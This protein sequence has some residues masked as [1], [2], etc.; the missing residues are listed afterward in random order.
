[1]LWNLIFSGLL[2]RGLLLLISRLINKTGQRQLQKFGICLRRFL[3]FSGVAFIKLGQFL[4]TRHDLVGETIA[5]ELRVLQNK[6]KPSS[7]RL[8]AKKLLTLRNSITIDEQP[9]ASGSISHVYKGYIEDN[10]KSAVAIKVLRP[11]IR[12][13]FLKNLQLLRKFVR[14]LAI[15]K[16]L[17][18]LRLEEA[19]DIIAEAAEVELNMHLEGAACDKLRQN[20]EQSNSK[21]RFP[22]VFWQFSSKNILVMEWIDGVP[23]FDKEGIE[24]LKINVPLLCYNIATSFFQQAHNDGFFHADIHGGN[25]LVS[26]TGIYMID[27]G[28]VSHLSESDKIAI[29]RIMHA[30]IHGD[31]DRVAEIHFA[32]GYIDKSKSKANFA[33][34]CRAIALPINNLAAN[35]ISMANMLIGI[36]E[37][38]RT[39]EMEGQP[40]LVLLQKTMI[41]LE[42]SLRH[43]NQSLNM[44]QIAKPWFSVWQ[45]E[46][47]GYKFALKQLL[48]STKKRIE[49][50][51]HDGNSHFIVTKNDTKTADSVPKTA[52]FAPKNSGTPLINLYRATLLGLALLL[53]LWQ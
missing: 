22:K 43:L 51:Y 32:A 19:I 10:A 14:L 21:L 18:R 12:Y 28:I 24:R 40:Q 29:A 38:M 30:F 20:A 8:M 34:A 7:A 13:R 52:D 35:K 49:S 41:S 5:A 2:Y 39:F 48:K 23:L 33:L 42:G 11:L 47:M 25:I 26:K 36:L 53:Y 3:L 6:V 46:N 37:L 1:L 45:R 9:I 16:S 17:R 27:C 44:W 31:F 4:A 50:E 15:S